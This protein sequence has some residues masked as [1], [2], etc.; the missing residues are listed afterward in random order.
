MA[1]DHLVFE[2]SSTEI[3]EGAKIRLAELLDS[4]AAQP[5]PRGSK[6]LA[7]LQ[8]GIELVE[9]AYAHVSHGGPTRADAEK[10]IQEAKDAIKQTQ[11]D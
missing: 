6:I 8:S 3:N 4:F 5:E 7:A 1:E 2:E 9:S 11:P 10:W